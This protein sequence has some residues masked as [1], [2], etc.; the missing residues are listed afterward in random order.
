MRVELRGDTLDT[1]WEWGGRSGGHGAP[2]LVGD[3]AT[4]EDDYI[5]P[6][7]V[8]IYLLGHF[9]RHYGSR[10][11]RMA[12]ILCV[13]IEYTHSCQLSSVEDVMLVKPDHDLRLE[14]HYLW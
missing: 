4:G 14:P 10:S 7:P 1:V 13:G 6:A 9:N 8:I 12:Y 11:K 2:P 3:C 5:A